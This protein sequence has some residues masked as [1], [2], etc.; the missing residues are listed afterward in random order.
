MPQAWPLP[1][2]PE[3]G[4]RLVPVDGFPSSETSSEDS[5]QPALALGRGAWPAWSGRARA[6]V[7]VCWGCRDKGPQS[8]GWRSQTQ[9]RAG[10]VPSV[11]FLLGR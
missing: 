8:W 4:G 1:A 11:A 3:G 7:C 5:G 2:V 10:P 6:S 9:A